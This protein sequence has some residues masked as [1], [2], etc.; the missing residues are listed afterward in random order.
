MAEFSATTHAVPL[1]TSQYSMRPSYAS[2]RSR[3][4]GTGR[5]PGNRNAS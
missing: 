2:N 4:I 5:E 1:R 3:S